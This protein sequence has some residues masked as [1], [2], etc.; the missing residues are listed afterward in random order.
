MTTEGPVHAAGTRSSSGTAS[1]L[2]GLLMTDGGLDTV[3]LDTP[4]M[5]G[6]A[7]NR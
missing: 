4:S 7:G 2:A 6:P 5:Y 3:T 1:Y